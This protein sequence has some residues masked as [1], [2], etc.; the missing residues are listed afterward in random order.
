ML[1]FFSTMIVISFLGEIS[2]SDLMFL[3]PE[4]T[5]LKDSMFLRLEV[6]KYF[7]GR[8]E[9]IMLFSFALKVSLKDCQISSVMNGIMG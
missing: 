9:I 6:P 7:V 8:S 4:I 5:D 1:L 3:I 2:I